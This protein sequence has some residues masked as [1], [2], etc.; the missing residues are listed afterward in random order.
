MSTGQERRLCR[1]KLKVKENGNNLDESSQLHTLADGSQLA[2]ITE[3]LYMLNTKFQKM[4][5]CCFVKLVNLFQLN[6]NL[7]YIIKIIAQKK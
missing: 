2:H 6:S 7:K 4:Q 3:V 5:W 1:E